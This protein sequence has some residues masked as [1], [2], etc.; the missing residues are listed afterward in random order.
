EQA[1]VISLHVDGRPSN[2]NLIGAKEFELMKKGVIFIN[3]S[4]GHIVD[5][6]ALRENVLN[7]KV[8]GC[9]ID[10]F[11]QEPVS[12][13]DEFVSVLRGLPNTILTP[14]IGGSTL[15]AQENIGNYVP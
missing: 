8:A 1:D 7:G 13:A 10:V 3:L 2:A 5:I 11:P 6:D 12:N 9:A 15:E 14:H 4:R